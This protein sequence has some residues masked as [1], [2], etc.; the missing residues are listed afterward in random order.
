MEG[1]APHL[2]IEQNKNTVDVSTKVTISTAITNAIHKLTSMNE[3][4]S[5]PVHNYTVQT[6]NTVLTF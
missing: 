3:M 2:C 5:L 1:Q 6:V 4:S